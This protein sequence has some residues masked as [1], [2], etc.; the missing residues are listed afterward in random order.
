MLGRARRRH[1][2]RGSRQYA[3]VDL[4]PAGSDARARTQRADKLAASVGDDAAG[5]SREVGRARLRS[6][7]I[8]HPILPA[9]FC[10]YSQYILWSLPSW[11]RCVEVDGERSCPRR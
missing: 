11:Q 8:A 2:G 6:P 7:R 5:A 10:T 3:P 1:Q 4:H 9:D